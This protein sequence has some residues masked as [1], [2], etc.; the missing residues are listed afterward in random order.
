MIRFST[1]NFD[2]SQLMF[3][4]RSLIGKDTGPPKGGAEDDRRNAVGTSSLAQ[5]TDAIRSPFT[6]YYR[7]VSISALLLESSHSNFQELWLFN[8][9]TAKERGAW[10]DLHRQRYSRLCSALEPGM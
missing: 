5:Q 1:N 2:L 10:H 6:V 7:S 9:Q 8:L 4:Q 3:N